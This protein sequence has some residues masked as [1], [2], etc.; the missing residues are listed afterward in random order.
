MFHFFTFISVN[1]NFIFEA[2]SNNN[3]KIRK[4]ALKKHIIH[5]RTKFQ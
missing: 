3:S 2:E 5:T 1:N 4:R